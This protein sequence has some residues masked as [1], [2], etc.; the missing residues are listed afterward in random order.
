MYWQRITAE[1]IE[2]ETQF[3]PMTPMCACAA[4]MSPLESLQ[5]SSEPPMALT[6][7]PALLGRL[8]SSFPSCS[9]LTSS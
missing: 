9:H 5:P 8:N 3:C 6:A 7:L 1:C 2:N 4:C